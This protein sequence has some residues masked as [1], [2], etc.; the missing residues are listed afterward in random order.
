MR[1]CIPRIGILYAGLV[2]AASVGLPAGLSAQE[3]A[4][5]PASA[6]APSASEAP[7]GA[8]DSRQLLDRYLRD[9]PQ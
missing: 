8:T 2:L 6:V 9:L 5:P 1:K 4:A 3:P 7:A